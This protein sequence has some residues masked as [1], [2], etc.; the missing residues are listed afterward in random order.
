MLR[1]VPRWDVKEARAMMAGYFN[2][3]DKLNLI[4]KMI[5]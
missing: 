3:T 1:P 4:T 2:D 5:G